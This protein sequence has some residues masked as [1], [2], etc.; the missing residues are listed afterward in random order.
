ML[1][2]GKTFRETKKKINRFSL[3]G[4]WMVGEGL[5]GDGGGG[6]ALL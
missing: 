5:Y 2:N 6:G 4:G 3:S 1:Q